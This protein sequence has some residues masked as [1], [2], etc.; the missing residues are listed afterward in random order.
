[1]ARPEV[2]YSPEDMALSVILGYCIG[3]V[4]FA[5]LLSRR[6]GADDLRR[7]GSGNIGAANVLRASGV[8]AGVLVAVLDIAKG[9]LSVALAMRLS[10]DVNA[11]AAA[12]LA[13]IIGHVYPAWLRFKGG[14]GV[15]TACGVFSVLTPY[16]ALPAF[17][18][19]LLTAWTTRYVSLG[20][21]VATIAL[22]PIAYVAG[23]PTASLVAACAAAVLILFRHRGNLMR[24]RSGTERRLGARA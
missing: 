20:S 11:P 4:P 23:S 10:S 19:F 15:A 17:C 3:S 7:I 18:M 13:A 22:P 24:L 6:W 9:A 5:W 21:V 14:K 12:G 16:A 8:R 1:M 2:G